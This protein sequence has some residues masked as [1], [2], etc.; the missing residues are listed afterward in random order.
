MDFVFQ[1]AK[2][3]IPG[4]R[5]TL[6]LEVRYTAC[7]ELLAYGYSKLATLKVEAPISDGP[8]Q[9]TWDLFPEPGEGQ[10]R[11]EPDPKIVKLIE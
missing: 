9:I 3:K 6:P 7:K 5:R 4:T 8:L 1:V 10:T 11:I 2:G